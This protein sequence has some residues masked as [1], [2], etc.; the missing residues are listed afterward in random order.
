MQPLRASV[1]ALVGVALLL[2]GCHADDGRA[3]P[4]PAA[5]AAQPVVID[6]TTLPLGPPTLV[7]TLV[8]GT[9]TWR[10]TTV[11]TSFPAQA[12]HAEI[13]GA[14][15]G[16]PVVTAYVEDGEDSGDRF[17]SLAADGSVRRLGATYQTYDYGPRLV[18]STGHVWAQHTDRTSP[19]TLWE[20]DARTGEQLAVYHRRAPHDLAPAD[21]ALVDAWVHRRRAAPETEDRTHD[22]AL[23][24]SVRTLTLGTGSS[25][26]A[27]VVRRTADRAEL[28]RFPFAVDDLTGSVDRVVFEDDEHVLALVT[29]SS[30]RRHG[31]RQAVVRCGV[32]T[33]ACERVTEVSG[34]VALG[35][36]R[37][38]FYP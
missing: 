13:L 30:T 6:V 3:V 2:T 33:G 37:P 15:D 22:G 38:R 11:R 10:G 19:L 27:V 21:Q 16:R 17:F 8:D 20:V 5:P 4:E 7:P 14:V 34:Q 26:P 28:A 31:T 1:A 18:A 9:L 36:V 23:K 12:V 25:V 24:A 29:L 35:V 32:A